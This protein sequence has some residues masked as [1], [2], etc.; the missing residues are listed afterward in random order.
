MAT[1][2]ANST[3]TKTTG[4]VSFSGT[5]FSGSALTQYSALVGGASNAITSVGPGTAGQ[6]LQSGGA[7]AN[8]S[9]S[10]ATYPSTAGTAGNIL[11]SNGTNFVSSSASSVGSSL[12]LLQTQTASNSASIVFTSK[13]SA[14]YLNYLLVWSNVV[15]VTSGANLSMQLSTDNGGTY[16]STNY[17]SGTTT[18]TYNSTTLANNNSTNSITLSNS[19]GSTTNFGCSGNLIMYPSQTAIGFMMTGQCTSLS[20]NT[21]Q[22]N[23]LFAF[24]SS[25]TVNA[26]KIDM[27]SGNINTGTFSLYGISN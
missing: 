12:T 6:V 1:T 13:I 10:T 18:N 9:Y 14:T 11:T 26:F 4:Q 27:S 16:L 8:P 24:N 25:T 20:N 22:N 19:M 21:L 2:P 23:V 17:Q 7:S 5:D 15:P 3:N